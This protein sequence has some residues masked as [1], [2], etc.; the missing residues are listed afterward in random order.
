[1]RQWIRDLQI[2]LW[3]VVVGVTM[4]LP[5]L[6]A[7]GDNLWDADGE[8]VGSGGLHAELRGARLCRLLPDLP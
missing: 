6:A 1:M 4:A 5:V 2:G 8:E 7:D 3:T